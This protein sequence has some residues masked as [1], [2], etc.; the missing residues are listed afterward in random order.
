[1]FV[2]YEHWYYG[3][4]NKVQMKPNVQEW[5]DEL[6]Q[7]YEI[8]NLYIFGDFSEPNIGTE[9]DML[10]GLTD[11]VVHTASTKEG[12]DKDFTDIIILDTIYRSMA[13]KNDDEVYIL[14]TGDAHFTKVVEYLK[15]KDKKVIIYGVKFAFSNALKS[16]ATSY[17]EMP[18][19][20][21]E[22]SHYNDLILISLDRLRNKNAARKPSYWKTIESVAAYN[23]VSKSRVKTAL[24]GMIS[25]KYIEV[26][27]RT[28]GRNNEY[29]QQLLEVDW[30]HLK[31]DG[32]WQ[33]AAR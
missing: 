27:T 16:A 17:V 22:R 28:T 31:E 5:I 13:E 6:Q 15:E 19:Q 9:L 7:E 4:H 10:K 12:V 20:E 30:A 8:H 11:H 25:Q 26:T 33:S 2:D 14:F 23:R 3:Y 21:Q 24:D 32:L 18:R 1:M 29:T